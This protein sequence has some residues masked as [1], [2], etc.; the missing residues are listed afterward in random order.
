[1][2]FLIVKHMQEASVYCEWSISLLFFSFAASSKG[3]FWRKCLF[4][5][6]AC[7]IILS[8]IVFFFLVKDIV[9]LFEASCLSLRFCLHFFNHVTLQ[10]SKDGF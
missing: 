9:T 1:L 4:K 7:C 10:R 8:K 6:D 3:N 5:G 2:S